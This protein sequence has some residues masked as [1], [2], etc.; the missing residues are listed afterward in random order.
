VFAYLVVGLIPLFGNGLVFWASAS[1]L[2]YGFIMIASAVHA[3]G[4]NNITPF[5]EPTGFNQLVTEGV[6]GAVRHPM[7]NRKS[8]SIKPRKTRIKYQLKVLLKSNK[9]L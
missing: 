7:C 8:P 6:Y 4:P 9:S 2:V 1:S 5:P 3:L